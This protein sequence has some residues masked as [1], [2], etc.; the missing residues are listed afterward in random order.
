MKIDFAIHSSDS[1]KLYL[2]FWPVIAEVWK[3]KFSITPILVYIDTDNKNID[4]SFGIVIKLKPIEGIPIHLQTQIVRFWIPILYPEKI[5]IISDIDMIPLS[6]NYFQTSLKNLPDTAYVHL[7]PCIESYGRLPACYHVA[8]GKTFKE[9]LEIDAEWETFI[10][11]I[12]S[13]DLNKKKFGHK[14]EFWFA[15]ELYSSGKVL[16][17]GDKHR[18]CLIERSGGQNGFR[19]DRATWK[20]SKFLLRYD[21]YID[22]HSV[23]PYIDF[24]EEIDLIKKL[25]INSKNRKA[26]ILIV[27]FILISDFFN[28]KYRFFYI[29]VVG[30]ITK[31]KT[32]FR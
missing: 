11:K 2:D 8:K 1:N 28:S 32:R 26:P 12:L 4:E 5:C 20:F 30:I 31:I 13:E 17:F 27:K 9:V 14:K 25:T 15:D 21:Y 29:R 19:I 3:K 24:K 22:S 6:K 18:L 23:R 10:R 7:N 16:G